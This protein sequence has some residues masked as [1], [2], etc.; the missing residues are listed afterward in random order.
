MLK[1]V[2]MNEAHIEQIAALERRCFTQPWSAAML[3]SELQSDIAVYYAAEEDGKACGYAGM[4]IT[5][6]V[7]NIT[8]VAVSPE[9]RRRGIADML[10][11]ELADA[12][13]KRRLSCL[14]L[15]VRA[16]NAPAISLYKKNGFYRAGVRKE[17]Y[18]DNHEDAYIMT[19]DFAGEGIG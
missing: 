3:M 17:Y 4:Y 18:R 2:P 10:L 14:T 19:R 12:A 15:E 9:T 11:R 16:S 7:G 8:K 5:A 1:I 13:E 6:D